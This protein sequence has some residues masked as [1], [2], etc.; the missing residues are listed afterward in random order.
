SYDLETYPECKVSGHNPGRL[1]VA[2]SFGI[3]SIHTYF[4]DEPLKQEELIGFSGTT[5]LLPNGTFAWSYPKPDSQDYSGFVDV[6]ASQDGEITFRKRERGPFGFP[7]VSH[8]FLKRP[9]SV[10]LNPSP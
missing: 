9:A 8:G 6:L 3:E 5:T 10:P 4:F 2:C 1:D 7:N